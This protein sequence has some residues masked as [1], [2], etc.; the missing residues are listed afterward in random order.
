MVT[1]TLH[2]G[3]NP[4]H[5]LDVIMGLEKVFDT[6]S[7]YYHIYIGLYI[8]VYL[9]VNNQIKLRLAK[10]QAIFV[11]HLTWGLVSGQVCF[12]AHLFGHK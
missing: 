2:G 1:I 8:Y 3:L 9:V 7:T 12:G 10:K 11:V 5:A 4:V 6:Y